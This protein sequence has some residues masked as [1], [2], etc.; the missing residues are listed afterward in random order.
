ML[1]R[2]FLVVS[3]IALVLANN[4][5]NDLFSGIIKNA[6]QGSCMV[7]DFNPQVTSTKR[8]VKKC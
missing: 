4:I 7:L 8:L 3:K 6:H 1:F 5:P 2:L